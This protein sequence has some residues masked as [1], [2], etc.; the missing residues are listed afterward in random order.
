MQVMVNTFDAG[1]YTSGTEML[2]RC[3]EATV[4][5]G[6]EVTALRKRHLVSTGYLVPGITEQA[7]LGMRQRCGL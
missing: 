5:I 4:Y 6:W 3:F 1:H 2:V 7:K